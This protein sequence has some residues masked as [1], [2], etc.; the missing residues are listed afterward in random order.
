MRV[1]HAGRRDSTKRNSPVGCR[2]EFADFPDSIPSS[3]FVP[4]VT[5]LRL[6]M[7]AALLSGSVAAQITTPVGY[8]T[9][10]G[11]AVFFHFGGVRRFQSIDNTQPGLAVWNSFALRRDGTTA[12]NTAY[13]ARTFDYQVRFASG[14]PAVI[15]NTMEENLVAPTTVY[16]LRPT[17][18]PDWQNP[19][20]TPPAPFDFSVTLDAP[21][22]HTGGAFIWDIE[23]SNNSQAGT[24]TMDRHY[25]AYLSSAGVLIAGSVGCIATGRAAAFAHTTAMRNGGPTGG[26]IGMHLQVTPTNCPS[27]SPVLLSIDAIDSAL[28]VPF[29]CATLH[30]FPTII[31]PIGTS[32]A[33]GT[34][35]AKHLT[36]PH[37]NSMVGTSLVSQL[38]SPDIGLSAPFLPLAL[39]NGRTTTMPANPTAPS[40]SACYIWTSTIGPAAAGT[41]FWGGCAIALLQ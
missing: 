6:S 41:V 1:S 35:T 20:A 15:S 40:E 7:F 23:H 5:N 29:L 30:A 27:S 25:N 37:I 24:V 19:P 2:P 33:T 16:A 26:S 9:V 3:S 4:T 11:N 31:L 18:F 39:S 38:V 10:E 28:T 8:N 22:V 12:L 32:S 21:Y 13:V 34:L 36:F 14:A 17:S